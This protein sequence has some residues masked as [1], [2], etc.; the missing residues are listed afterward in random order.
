MGGLISRVSSR[1]YRYSTFIMRN[2]LLPLLF[3][4]AFAKKDPVLYCDV[5]RGI[6]AEYRQ[7]VKALGTTAKTTIVAGQG[8]L[9]SDGKLKTKKSLI[10]KYV[11]KDWLEEVFEDGKI[12]NAISNDYVKWFGGADHKQWR[13]GR[14]MTYDGKMNTDVDLGYLQTGQGEAREVME[15][16]PSDR[17]RS[18]RWYC[19]NT[20]EDLEERLYEALSKEGAYLDGPTKKICQEIAGWCGDDMVDELY[21]DTMLRKDEL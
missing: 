4:I 12:C 21:P 14:I 10:P 3:A 16:D 20:V 19:E 17:T 2:I 15:K 8:R 5:C 1:T 6:I 11:S 13:I 9:S 18:L 7:A